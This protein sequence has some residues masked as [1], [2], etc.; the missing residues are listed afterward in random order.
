VSRLNIERRL[1]IR[2]KLTLLCTGVMAVLL[3]ALSGFLYLRFRSDLDYNIDQSLR[4]RAAEIAS[5]VAKG[6]VEQQ[7]APET[8]PG[9]GATFV[10]ILDLK[11]SVVDASAGYSTPPLLRDR[12]V[13]QAAAQPLLLQRGQS[14][15]LYAIPVNHGSSIVVA[16]VS[17]AQRNAAFDKL[18]DTLLTG[19][20]LALLLAA[21]LAYGLAAAALRPVESMRRRAASI[22]VSEPDARLPL[23]SSVDEI[24]L[25][26]ATLNEMLDRLQDGLQ[27]ERTFLANASHELRTPLAVLKAELEVTLREHGTVAQLRGA[28]ASAAEETDRIIGLAEDLLV[29]ARAEQGQLP[30]QLRQVTLGELLWKLS[31]KLEPIAE[32]AGRSLQ[33][34]NQEPKLIV[35]AD[36][37]RLGQALGN[38]LDNALRYG[39]GTVSL[40]AVARGRFLELHLID[41]GPG[42][43][44]EF[45][46]RAFERF[47]RQDP[48]RS[49]GG[50]GLGLSI[51]RVIA[52]AHGGNAYARNPPQGG[53]DVW[54][55][56]PCV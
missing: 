15:R 20:P 38:L 24:H 11:G 14:L 41:H 21:I 30:I 6:D 51:V 55:T 13:D 23:P 28:L 40:S 19:G 48:A 37:D 1:P 49:R 29:L 2:L 27:R 17:L 52:Q 31:E 50:A 34:D 7:Q 8:L 54:L 32:H 26:G 3:A 53:A 43:D 36:L 18:E 9:R 35:E 12:E 5:L 22:S 42:F 39:R 33:T 16:G 44:A 10:Q 46:P 56:I 47:S 45:L 4:A 25:L